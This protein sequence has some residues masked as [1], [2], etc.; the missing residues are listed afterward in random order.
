MSAFPE[1]GEAGKIYIAKDTNKTYRWSGSAYTEISASLALGE[2]SS[3]AYRGDRGKTAYDHSQVVSGNP[4]KVTASDVGAVPTSRKVNGKA[5]S[6]DITLSASDVGADASGSASSALTNAKA[7]TDAEINEWVGDKT[8]AAQIST[9]IANKSDTGHT[10]DDRYY[11]ETEINTKLS[12]KSDTTHKHD[13]TY[14]AKSHGTHVPTPETANNAKFLRNDNTWQTVTPANIGAAA[15]S[16]GTHVSY[17]TTAP[18]MDGTASVGSA[19]TVARSDHKHPTDTSRAAASDLTALQTLVGDKKVS[20]QIAAAQMIYVGPTRPT[21]PNIKV[22]INT[23]E[24]GTG[25]VPVLPRVATITLPASA[26]T[27]SSEPYSQ[28]VN[29]ATVTTSSKIDLQPSAQQIVDLQNAE[30]SLMIGNDG[31]VVTC[32]AIGNKPTVNYTMQVLIQEVAYV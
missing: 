6:S 1:T 18:V 8:V 13:D 5:L 26:W 9:A 21:D 11:T 31:G 15:S 12:G 19:A 4:H 32:Y 17:S 30:T 16:H 23:S 14:A 24:E 27:G 29:I 7:Y 3:T 25:V 2:T 28:V 20:E 10:H 22:W